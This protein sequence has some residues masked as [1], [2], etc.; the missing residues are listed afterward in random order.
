MKKLTLLTSVLLTSSVFAGGN[1]APIVEEPIVQIPE[2]IVDESAFY[3]GLGY[4][5]FN[6]TNESIAG[7][8]TEVTLDI[9]TLFVQAGYQYN[10]YIAIEGRYWYGINDLTV[11]QTSIPDK[12]EPGDYSAWGIYLKP[13]YPI[14]DF[15]IYGLLGYASVELTADNNDYWDTDSFSAGIGSQYTFENG[16]SIFADYVVMG[17]TDEFDSKIGTTTIIESDIVISTINFGLNYS[18]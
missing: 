1:I 2:V 11:G 13:T 12:E 7:T 3:L 8:A 6:Q 15:N 16:I 14:G 18:F 17:Y 4:G 9:D 10:K 5:V